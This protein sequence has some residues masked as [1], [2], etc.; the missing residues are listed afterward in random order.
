[1]AGQTRANCGWPRLI[2]SEWNAKAFYQ[3]NPSPGVARE[4]AVIAEIMNG[5]LSPKMREFSTVSEMIQFRGS[6]VQVNLSISNDYLTLGSNAQSVRTPLSSYAAQYLASQFGFVLPTSH[7]VDLIFTQADTRL[8]P[9]PTDWYKHE[10]QM[11]L[12]PN[13]LLHH[14]MIERQRAN[15]G[16]LLAGHKKDVILTNLLDSQ[17][18]RVAIYGWHRKNGRPIQPVST[19]HNLDYEDYSHGIRFVGPWVELVDEQGGRTLIPTPHALRDPVLGRWLNGGEAPLRDVRAARSCPEEFL[20]ATGL[21]AS[22]CPPQ[23]SLCDSDSRI[24]LQD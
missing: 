1:M 15:R 24:E 6:P 8:E 7:I 12:G 20:K 10:G 23:P 17:P 2:N 4:L 11:H 14:E 13:Y 16:G 21:T 3:K 9:Q 5:N 18:D 22:Q 19:P